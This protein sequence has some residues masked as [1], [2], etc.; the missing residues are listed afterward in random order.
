MSS[1]VI[2]SAVPHMQEF[3]ITAMSFDYGATSYWKGP[4]DRCIGLMNGL[5]TEAARKRRLDPVSQVVD[6]CA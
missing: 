3:N 2:G 1:L 5:V 6:V 4:R